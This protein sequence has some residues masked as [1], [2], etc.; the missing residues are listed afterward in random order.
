MTRRTSRPLLVFYIL[1]VYVILQ[2]TWWTYL[3]I[4][5]NNQVYYEKLNNMPDGSDAYLSAEALLKKKWLMIG[6]E[7]FVFFTLLIAGLYLVRQ[8]LKKEALVLRQQKNFLLSVTHELKSPL[9]SVRLQTETLK[10]HQLTKEM[11]EQVIT[12]ALHDIERLDQL[13]ENI[14]LATRLDNPSF[15]ISKTEVNL[16][17]YL[18]ECIRSF[19]SVN[20]DAIIKNEVTDGVYAEIDPL[21]FRSII[22]NLLENAYKYGSKEITVGLQD[23]ENKTC[24]TI[25]DTGPG[26]PDDEKDHIFRIFY[27]IGSEDTRKQ[28]GTGLG[29]YIAK[30]IVERHNGTINVRS[31]KPAGSIFE[32][33]LPKKNV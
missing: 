7:A 27:R 6:G 11:Q 29:L 17:E 16:S 2:F 26:I 9:A 30:T 22:V 13:V 21:L 8:S 5:L 12:N 19:R 1:V 32:I 28:K 10:K 4:D 24:I 20:Q 14:L 3:I 25:C 33:N 15:A 31:N 23:A 18:M